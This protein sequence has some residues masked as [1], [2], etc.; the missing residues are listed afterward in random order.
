MYGYAGKILHVNL[1]TG[2]IKTEPL[3]KEFA[4][5]YIGGLGFGAKI[6]LDLI[7]EEPDFDPLSPE[8]PF[9]VMTGPLTGIRM[10]AVARWTVCSK[11]PLTGLWGECN[12]G[13]YFGAE[14][15]FAGYDGIV[16]TGESK[17]PV[18]LYIDNDTVQIRDAGRYWGRDVYAVNDEMIMDLK[19]ESSRP[20]QVFTIG[21]AGENLV[22]FAS[23]IHKKG[24]VAG[25][26]GLGAV[27]GAKKLK[28]VFVRGTGKLEI[29]NPDRLAD[30][31]KELKEVYADS[32]AMEALRSFG[33]A[34]HMDVGVICGD[35]PM[36]NWQQSEWEHFD[37]IGPIAYG[38]QLLTGKSTCFACGVACKREAE[39]KEGPFKFVKG[40]GPEYETVASFGTLCLNPSIQSIGKANDICNRYGMDTISCGSTIAFAIECFEKGLINK[41]DTNGIELTWG[42]SEGIVAMTEM[43]GKREG[44]GAV[45][46][47]GS[48]KAAGK[49]GGGAED[50]LTTVKGLEAPMHDTRFAHG[51]GLA[52]AVSPRGACHMASLNYPVESGSMY[53]P[54]I[55]EL[56]ADIIESSSDGKAA[57]NIACQDFGMFFSSCA[58]FCNIGALPLNAEQAVN[59]VNHVTG[60]NYTIEEVMRIGR[61]IWY[62]KR[63][64]SNLFGAR[65]QDDRLPKR[66]LTPLKTGPTEGSTP[67]MDLMLREFYAMRGLNENGLPEKEVLEK[68]GLDAL[69]ALLENIKAV[70]Y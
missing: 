4:R 59:M 62:L 43:I 61:R 21:P 28:A 67:D 66:L 44:F 24:H 41:D 65:K 40:P 70:G 36:K 52:Y 37:D 6:Y 15:K 19:Q 30:Q 32:I 48:E 53:V 63:G 69:A 58:I 34:A 50:S 23:I 57:L 20:G 39:V 18:Y 22:R 11:S 9:I 26:T 5:E 12:I 10:N 49:I 60:F 16:I 47:E 45:L 64:L 1:S 25:R 46:A 33:T 3:D 56:A 17:A 13:G 14:L 8:N 51:Y 29:A 7:K 38:E 42:N 31:K 68:N 55:P 27:W 54:D 2:T 35:I